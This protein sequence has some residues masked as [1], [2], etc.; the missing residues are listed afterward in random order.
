MY[1]VTLN[2][3]TYCT[4]TRREDADNYSYYLRTGR[5][6]GKIEIISPSGERVFKTLAA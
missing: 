6:T 5:F 2:G 3:E 4:C 1:R